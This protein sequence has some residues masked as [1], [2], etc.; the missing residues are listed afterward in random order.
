MAELR[1]DWS[2]MS[3]S[4]WVRV[5]AVGMSC[6]SLDYSNW[7]IRRRTASADL[8]KYWSNKKKACRLIASWVTCFFAFLLSWRMTKQGKKPR[9]T[10]SRTFDR[11]HRSSFQIFDRSTMAEKSSATTKKY[12]D[13]F[14]SVEKAI[15]ENNIFFCTCSPSSS[16]KR[17]FYC[18]C[19]DYN[20]RKKK[21]WERKWFNVYRHRRQNDDDG[22]PTRHDNKRREREKTRYTFLFSSVS[23][24]DLHHLAVCVYTMTTDSHF[25][26]NFSLSSRPVD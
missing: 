11:S 22:N 17:W 21:K 10:V 18:C 5:A 1:S 14:D 7:Q 20:R 16:S 6:S 23:I 4:R 2:S 24:I 8:S 26:D 15:D 12:V 25:D 3:N 13:E 19:S 9:L